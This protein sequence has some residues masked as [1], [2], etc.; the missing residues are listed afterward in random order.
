MQ[1][2]TV[3]R[4]EEGAQLLKLLQKRL[5]KA[6]ISFFYKMLRKKNITL[7]GK[8]AEGK[9]ILCAGDVIELF[10]SDETIARFGGQ[11]A[12]TDTFAAS[13]NSSPE[14]P[15]AGHPSGSYPFS[16]LYED[17][18]LLFVCKP[19]GLLTQ[20]AAES[21]VSLNEHILR[22]LLDN[23]SLTKEALA[24]FRP[25]VCNRLDRNTSGIVSAGKTTAGL[26]FLSSVFRERTVEKYYYCI[27]R[28]ELFHPVRLDGFLKKDGVSNQ[29]EVLSPQ[30]AERAEAEG[31]ERII[32]AFRPLQRSSGFTLL[33]VELVTGRPHQIRAHLAAQE[34]PIVGDTKYG[35]R[36]VN[37][38][39]RRDFG[40]KYQ[41]LHAGRLVFQPQSGRFSYLSGREIRAAAPKLFEK[42]CKGLGFAEPFIPQSGKNV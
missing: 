3:T 42:V 37:D 19:A 12:G 13:G 33:E 32:T 39:V 41:L 4:Y 31:Y 1:K 29:V 11:I 16:V 15:E 14:M 18:D 21:D 9:E 6:P 20:K 27:V 8:R 25:G 28:G 38:R 24:V 34:H 2:I 5:Q 30:E 36:A 26:Q 23:G 17:D 7:N 10:L 35:D 22:L 40:L